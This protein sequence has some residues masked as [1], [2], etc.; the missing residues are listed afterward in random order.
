ML[1]TKQSTEGKYIEQDKVILERE[2]IQEVH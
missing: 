1:N 2:R